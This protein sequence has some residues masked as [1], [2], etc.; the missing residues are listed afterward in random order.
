[1]YMLES[2]GETLESINVG[3]SISSKI[4]SIPGSPSLSVLQNLLSGKIF[5]AS[6]VL[7]GA[8]LI[9]LLSK[10]LFKLDS[11][12]VLDAKKSQIIQMPL[13][14]L[15]ALIHYLRSLQGNSTG[16]SPPTPFALRASTGF[17]TNLPPES[18]LIISV[19][20]QADFT[21]QLYTPSLWLYVPI[22]SFPG[23]RGALPL[24]ILGLLETIFVRCVVPPETTGLKPLPKPTKQESSSLN[25]Q[26]EELLGILNRFGKYFKP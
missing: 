18:P 9:L 20:I 15:Q 6:G 14:E 8:E 2:S 13:S 23:L 1:M 7:I 12:P 21:N 4:S 24:L 22:L 10:Y 3:I 19:Y 11:I 5:L 16:G 26:P 25:L 17:P